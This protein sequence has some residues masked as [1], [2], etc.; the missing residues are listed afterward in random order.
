MFII[1]GLL[2]KFKKIPGGTNLF[3]FCCCATGVHACS[4]YT[5]VYPDDH[6]AEKID[7][8]AIPLLIL[9]TPLTAIRSKIPEASLKVFCWVA[10][11]LFSAAFLPPLHRT[12]TFVL[13]GT[14]LFWRYY[15]IVNVNLLSQ[16]GLYLSGAFFFIRNG[17]HGRPIGI[18]DHH[19][20]H[21][22]VTAGCLLHISYI[23][24]TITYYVA[25]ATSS[26]TSTVTV[27]AA[28]AIS[29]VKGSHKSV[30]S[31]ATPVKDE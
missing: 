13:L 4:A 10:F 3:I 1:I 6:I 15:A 11:G 9:G 17:G 26:V 24:S 16:I 20:L 12:V 8:L 7:H 25:S 28:E 19:M 5:H 23:H 22:C 29:I 21:Y 27:A 14:V 2:A 30:D 18:Q 31:T